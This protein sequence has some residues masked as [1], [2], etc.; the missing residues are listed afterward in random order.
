MSQHPQG[1][2]VAIDYGMA[3]IGLAIS[4]AQRIIATPLVTLQAKKKTAASAL[5]CVQELQRLEKVGRYTIQEIVVGLPLLLS[6]KAGLLADEVLL[7]VEHLKHHL[8]I[9]ITTWDERLTSVQADRTLR[10]GHLTRK[11]RA[12]LV[13]SVSA[14]LLLQTYLDYRS[15][16]PFPS[17]DYT[18]N[19]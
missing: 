6:G 12:K 15:H 18:P 13:D 5:A 4:D 7:F 16:T 11:K 8:S 3:R 17:L 14:L 19:D 10:E 2:I 9:P 1:R